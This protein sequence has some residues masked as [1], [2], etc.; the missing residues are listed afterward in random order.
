MGSREGMNEGWYNGC[1]WVATY[2]ALILLGTPEHPAE[3]VRY[4]ETSGGTVFGGVFGT[5][6]NSIES[7]IRSLGFSVNHAMFPQLSMNIDNAI[8]A[9][10]VSILAYV[11]T[12]AAH[13]ATIEYREDIGKFVVYNDR[14]ARTRSESL[15]FQND[16]NVGA[17]IDSIAA[18]INNTPDILFS[19]SLITVG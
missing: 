11:H 17:V 9:S 13:Y 16:T 14:F 1:G 19:F 4:F 12:S 3:I 10:R 15:G 7:Y 8:K 5:Y 6:P 18:F 2:N